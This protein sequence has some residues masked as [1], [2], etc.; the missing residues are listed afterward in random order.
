MTPVAIEAEMRQARAQLEAKQRRR[1]PRDD[2][3]RTAIAAR[4][5]ALWTLKLNLAA[6]EVRREA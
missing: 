3:R 4:L 6:Q 2:R 1:R 5:M